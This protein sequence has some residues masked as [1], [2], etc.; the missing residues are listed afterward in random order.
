MSALS[1]FARYEAVSDS[2][3]ESRALHAVV[4]RVAP[5]LSDFAIRQAIR[6]SARQ[7]AS[8][9]RRRAQVASVSRK[10][11][12]RD[13][14][15]RNEKPQYALRCR[16]D[17]AWRNPKAAQNPADLARAGPGSTPVVDPK[18]PD[19]RRHRAEPGRGDQT[20]L[21]AVRTGEGSTELRDRGSTSR[22]RSRQSA[23]S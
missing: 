20:L 13:K 6:P 2:A 16:H 9:V 3:P 11:T 12:E 10:G 21:A 8:R 1:D 14:R 19:A 7:C 23:Q 5:L 4:V 15:S 22:P 17:T 18:R